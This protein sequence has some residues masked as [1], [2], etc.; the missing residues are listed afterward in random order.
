M[1]IPAMFVLVREGT[2][3]IKSSQYVRVDTDFYVIRISINQTLDL[4]LWQFLM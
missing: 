4:M 1:S 3:K 2:V